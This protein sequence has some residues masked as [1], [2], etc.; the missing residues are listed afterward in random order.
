MFERS[1]RKPELLSP[2]G[3]WECAR[4]A[5]ANGADA[6]YF[7]LPSFNARLRATNFTDEDL[8]RLIEFLHAHGVKGYVAFNTLIFTK[9]LPDAAKQLRLV[10][11]AG[12][13]AAIVQDVGLCVLAKAL[14]P[15]LHLHASTQMTLTSPEGLEFAKRL[16]ITR[17]VLA[18]ELSLRDLAKFATEGEEKREPLLPLEVFV[19]GALCVAYSGQCLTSEALG[20]RSA[21]RGECAQACRMPYQM[22]VDCQEKE[23]GDRRYLLSPQ[24]LAAVE[25]IPDL[26]RAGIE[27]FKI[28]GRLKSPEY[29]AAVTR[30]YRSAIDRAWEA[31]HGEKATGDVSK[32]ERYQLE[33]AFSRGLFSGWLDGVNH[34]QLVHARFGKKRGALIG[35]IVRIGRDFIE[36]A[37]GGAPVK[38]GDGVVIDAGGDT[39]TEQGGRVYQ[40]EEIAPGGM[41]L[42]FEHGKLRFR[43]ILPGHLLWKTDDPQLNKAL[44]ASFDGELPLP[45]VGVYFGLSGQAGE[46]LVLRAALSAEGVKDGLRVESTMD[47]QAAINRPMTEEMFREQLGR[48]GDT[49]FEL[50]G[51]VNDVQGPVILPIKELNR[52][53]RDVVA[54]LEQRVREVAAKQEKRDVVV[55]SEALE[56]ELAR[57]KTVRGASDKWQPQLVVL[58]RNF[59]QVQ[60]ALES[61]VQMIYVDFED[62][63]RYRDAV[64]MVRAQSTT[65]KI[66][67]ATPRIHKPGETGVFRLMEKAVPDGYLVRNL[68]ALSYFRSDA[69]ESLRVGDFSLNV[70]NPL[71]AGRFMAE[72]LTRIT[73]S[74][75]LNMTFAGGG[76]HQPAE[77]LARAG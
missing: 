73:V 75:D 62:V 53:R 71:T 57:V 49:G 60:A 3:D 25:H 65:A 59:E 19:H 17:A 37:D 72:G 5:V 67:L 31:D 8:P 29:V 64:E 23:L 39:E 18:R 41:R 63:R 12:V 7:G 33:M 61:N 4:A 74:Y 22:V 46:K 45:K 28:E 26:M 77:P 69:P 47:L 34:Q 54:P 10:H 2:A 55:N 6:I 38:P 27:S 66:L 11:E 35:T 21:N 20:Q 32:E 1:P 52:M 15:D 16:G 50:K 30:V 9:E 13:D 44:R 58:C 48:L 56:S 43:E 70:A 36:V 40:A 68:G 76:F 42:R 14:V 51:L 24:D